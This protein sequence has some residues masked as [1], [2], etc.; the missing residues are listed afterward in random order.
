MCVRDHLALLPCMSA[1]VRDHLTL[2]PCMRACVRECVVEHVS[3]AVSAL[4]CNTRCSRAHQADSR[5]PA[6]THLPAENFSLRLSPCCPPPTLVSGSL[7]FLQVWFSGND[8]EEQL[9]TQSLYLA[10][11]CPTISLPVIPSNFIILLPVAG[12]PYFY[13]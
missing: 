8:E 1:C 10:F 11:F 3:P 2:L 6:V 7:L 9:I 5:S 13:G 4:V 12:L